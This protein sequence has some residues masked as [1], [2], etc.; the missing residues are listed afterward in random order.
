VFIGQAEV[1]EYFFDDGPI[2]IGRHS[3]ADIIVNQDVVSRKHAV[4]RCDGGTTWTVENVAGKNGLFVNGKFGAFHFLNN[5]DKIELG[6]AFIL[7]S[8]EEGNTDTHGEGG[9]EGG[10]FRSHEEVMHLIRGRKQ[11]LKLSSVVSKA[12]VRTEPT[13]ALSLEEIESMHLANKEKSAAHLAFEGGDNHGEIIP[14]CQ[15]GHII[16]R[17]KKA[18]IQVK[19]GMGLGNAFAI[20]RATDEQASLEPCSRFV[21]VTVN[22]EKIDGRVELVHGDKIGVCKTTLIYR[23]GL[24]PPV[25]L[26]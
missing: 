17:G 12:E 10:Y 9:G 1:G 7:F 22:Q 4:I 15:H 24:K 8:A 5:G 23:A 11:E 16:G 26:G 2:K 3:D 13:L 20:L 6:R 19:G 25:T 21:S 14:L 18:D